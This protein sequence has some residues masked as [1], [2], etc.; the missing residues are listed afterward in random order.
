MSKDPGSR[1]E[2]VVARDAALRRISWWTAALAVGAVAGTAG[3]ATTARSDAEAK[4]A[5]KLVAVQNASVVEAEE[6]P[7]DGTG[8]DG[9]GDAGTGDAGTGDDE[10][11]ADDEPSATG[12]ASPAPSPTGAVRSLAPG[13]RTSDNSRSSHRSVPRA[14]ASRRRAAVQNQNGGAPAPAPA[15]TKKKRKAAQP[16]VTSAGS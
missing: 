2:R 6:D 10:T 14:T 12:D 9:T 13:P 3:V 1:Q 8:D 5:A 7:A 11:R 16:A 4:A 15:P